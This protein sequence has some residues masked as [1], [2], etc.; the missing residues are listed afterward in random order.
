MESFSV[1][2]LLLLLWCAAA[3]AQPLPVRHFTPDDGLSSLSANAVAQ[4][5]GAFLWIASGSVLDRY[6]GARLGPHARDGLGGRKVK[7]LA[8]SETGDLWAAT[9]SGIWRWQPEAP[10]FTQIADFARVGGPVQALLALGGGAWAGTPRG[11]RFVRSDGRVLRPRR[12][13]SLLVSALAAH[14][15]ALFVA[16]GNEVARLDARTGRVIQRTVLP[17]IRHLAATPEAVWAGDG[18][19]TVHMLSLATLELLQA[20]IEV[21]VS[22]SAMEAS[23]RGHVWVGTRGSGLF[24]VDRNGARAVPLLRVRDDRQMAQVHMLDLNEE[25][26]SLWMGTLDGL[27][28]ADVSPPRFTSVVHDPD[29]PGGLRV[30]SV[31]SVYASR[32]APE[33]VWVG[34]V[35]G[36]LHRYDRTTGEAD[37]WFGDPDH[38]LSVLFALHETETGDLWLGA[39]S[40]AVHRFVSGGYESVPLDE[41]REGYITDFVPSREASGDLWVTTSTAG[42]WR[43]SPPTR[44]A[45]PAFLDSTWVWTVHEPPDEPGVLYAATDTRGLIRVETETGRQERVS[46]TTCDLDARLLS[47]ASEPDGSLWIG[48]FENRVFRYDRQTGACRVYTPAD[49]VPDESVGGVMVDARGYVWLSTNAGLARL[50]PETHIITPF[51]G[52]DGVP[53]GGLYFSARDQTP[54]GE[55]L[56]GGTNGF[57]VF[58]PLRVPINETPAPVRLTTIFV[59]GEPVPLADA[60]G[61]LR[62]PYYQNDLEVQYAALDLRQPEKTHYRVRLVGADDEWRPE[63]PEVRYAPLAPGRY[64]LRVSATNRDGYWSEPTELAVHIRPPY[65]Q[66]VWFWALVAALVGAVGFAAHRYRVEQLMRVERA[67]R[68][69]ADD[70]HDDIGSKISSVALRLDAARRSPTLSD[71]ERDRLARLSATTRAV[72]GDLRDTVWLVD[73]G[74]DTLR[75]VADRIERFAGEALAGGR[76]RVEREGEVPDVRLSMEARRDL[77]LL[78]TEALHNA[79]RHA[80]AETIL[81][82]IT[83]TDDAFVVDIRDDGRGFTA[84]AGGDGRGMTTMRRRAEALGGDLTIASEPSNGTRVTL[85]VPTT[86]LRRLAR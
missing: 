79:V 70:L 14:D 81:V 3:A 19:G 27:L 25:A 54:G 46:P 23:E 61:G 52:A 44:T 74:Q 67:R 15:G 82:R 68:R 51:S 45:T 56:V 40:L 39:Q 86:R 34:T 53:E 64:T 17:G 26:G 21:G 84:E 16:V 80:E 8:A 28:H 77:Y 31:M 12:L 13:P 41:S 30:P 5:P 10:A 83:N 37:R 24:T 4:S 33:A 9:G 20:P 60:L 2:G 72:V 29:T 32:L 22:I 42:I 11:L 7:R 50:D 48:S 35:S 18:E 59:D 75:S 49:G 85:H 57:T 62:L 1:S 55:I 36:G 63:G 6:D 47:L 78:A 76:G 58:D 69:I 66:T 71:A 65:W 43:F 73:A 38:P